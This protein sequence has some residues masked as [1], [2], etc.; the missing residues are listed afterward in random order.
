MF[1]DSAYAIFE[2]RKRA[3]T[4]EDRV[5]LVDFKGLA[6]QDKK[7]TLSE[8]S[9]I[10]FLLMK[11]LVRKNNEVCRYENSIF[12]YKLSNIIINQFLQTTNRPPIMNYF[13]YIST[14][15][16]TSQIVANIVD[17]TRLIDINWI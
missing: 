2:V 1:R 12:F 14:L 11:I 4:R 10:N 17:E 7:P 6:L 16:T 13:L 3:I 5:K 9:K 15:W 8:F